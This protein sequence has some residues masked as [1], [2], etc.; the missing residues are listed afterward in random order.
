MILSTQT[1]IAGTR[2]GEENVI[3][4][5]CE[6]G[7]DAIDYSMF[8]MRDEDDYVLNTPEYEKHILE[9]KKIA[10]S[11]G[12]FFNQAHAP[13]PSYKLG[14]DDYNE[15]ILERIKRSIEIAG[16]LGVKNIVVHPTDFRVRSAKNIRKNAEFYEKLIPS[17]KEYGV[18]VAVENMFGRDRRRDCIVPNICS[19]PEEFRQM[20]E[21]LDPEYFTACVDIGHAGLVGTTAPELIREL[22]DDYL[23]CLHVHDNDYLRDRHYPPFMFDLDWDEIT[24][25]LADIDYAGD[26][27][28]EADN[29]FAKIPVEVIPSA[30]KFLYE[31][32]RSLVK[33]IE[34]KK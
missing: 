23:G 24:Q 11:Y 30:M 33:M 28:F 9:L 25:A 3:K 32:G 13:F 5:I 8:R 27:T 19:L 7:F 6:T 20:M 15:K 34:E 26:F 2:I 1:D 29:I 17:C 18:K 4:L 21:L 14:E 10:E 12:K 22:G 16:I 31:I